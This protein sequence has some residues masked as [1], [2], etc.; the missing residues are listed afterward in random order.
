MKT[1][2]YE[3]LEKKFFKKRKNNKKNRIYLTYNHQKGKENG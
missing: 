3:T 1:I 2:T